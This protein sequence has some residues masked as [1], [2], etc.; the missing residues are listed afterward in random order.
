M[1]SVSKSQKRLMSMAYAYKKG[2]LALKNL[3]T[4]YA[5]KIRHIADSMSLKSLRHYI[6]TNSDSL[7]EY[8][9]ESV[10][11]VKFKDFI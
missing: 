6:K 10:R 4:K 2:K 11:I 3:D 9:G 5:E 7:P 1:P 8:K